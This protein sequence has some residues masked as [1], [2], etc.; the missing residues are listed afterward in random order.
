M[1]ARWL[2]YTLPMSAWSTLP[3]TYTSPTS[4]S[5]MISV[6]CEPSTRIELT[7]SPTSTLRDSTSPSI[8][9]TMVELRRSSSARSSAALACATCALAR[10][11]SARVT[12]TLRIAIICLLSAIW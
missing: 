2:M 11:M 8:G 9:L 12:D 3:S 10:A 6:A 4:P 1:R 7:A 5:V